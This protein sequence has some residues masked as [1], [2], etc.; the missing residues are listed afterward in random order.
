MAHHA[1]TEIGRLG[2]A[3]A[4]RYLRLAGYRI[5]ERNLRL[6]RLEIDLVAEHG[7][8]ICFVEVRL[9]RRSRFGGAAETIGHR[10]RQHLRSAARHYLQ[11][12]PVARCRFDVIAIE[13]RDEH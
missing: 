12:R 2:E 11:S 5:I 9:R 3:I 7:D 4:E 1:S 10:K 8:Q 13:E 6:S